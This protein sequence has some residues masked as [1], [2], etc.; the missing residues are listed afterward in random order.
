LRAL[1]KASGVVDAHAHRFRHTPATEILSNGGTLAGV[2]DILGISNP[3]RTSYAKWNQARQDRIAVLVN[4]IH[5]GTN[6]AHKK[7]LVVIR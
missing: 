4:T 1:F 2:A 3:S 5:S 6:R 7:K